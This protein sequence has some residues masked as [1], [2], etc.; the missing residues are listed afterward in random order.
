M[1][2]SMKLLLGLLCAQACVFVAQGAD[3]EGDALLMQRKYRALSQINKDLP[4]L[5]DVIMKLGELQYL[6]EDEREVAG[7][8]LVQDARD[9]ISEE[10]FANEIFK[11]LDDFTQATQADGS[12]EYANRLL[13]IAGNASFDLKVDVILAAFFDKLQNDFPEV[14]DIFMTSE[15]ALSND[16]KVAALELLANQ[17]APVAALPKGLPVAEVDLNNQNMRLEQKINEFVEVLKSQSYTPYET[18]KAVLWLLNKEGFIEHIYQQAANGRFSP[19]VET[20]SRWLSDAIEELKL[21]ASTDQQERALTDMTAFFGKLRKAGS[22]DRA[23]E[24]WEHYNLN[25]RFEEFFSAGQVPAASTSVPVSAIPGPVTAPASAPATSTVGPVVARVGAPNEKVLAAVLRRVQTNLADR[26]TLKNG[27]AVLG[28]TLS[29]LGSDATS[30][31]IRKLLNSPSA[32]STS[33]AQPARRPAATP[34]PA[35]VAPRPATTPVPAP[36]PVAASQARLS[37]VLRLVQTNMADRQRLKTGGEVFGVRLSNL[38]SDATSNA[39]RT[40]VK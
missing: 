35:L 38:G 30:N 24:L 4:G 7:L 15:E 31:A 39:I 13:D 3:D 1:K 11:V 40:L 10:Y 22:E 23:R 25:K 9:S 29:M 28:V 18:I 34:A 6:P 12:N 16:A 32:A 19:A 33:V 36:A 17:G 14:Y 27:G 2:F 26:Q 5:I 8:S 20:M 21:I 37:Q